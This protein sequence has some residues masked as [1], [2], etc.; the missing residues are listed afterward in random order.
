MLLALR[1]A[2]NRQA[3]VRGNQ[4]C[5]HLVHLQRL[6]RLGITRIADEAFI[7][8]RQHQRTEDRFVEEFRGVNAVQNGQALGQRPALFLQRTAVDRRIRAQQPERNGVALQ[9]FA[10]AG[11]QQLQ[12]TG[13]RRIDVEFVV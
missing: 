4:L 13:T 5:Q 8:Q 3:H 12:G 9:R 2:L 1:G 6:F 11:R 7:A 10:R